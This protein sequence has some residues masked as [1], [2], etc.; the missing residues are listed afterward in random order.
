MKAYTLT[1]HGKPSVLKIAEVPEPEPNAGE[2][3]IKIKRIGIN[4]AEI[5]SRKGMYGWA[6][7]LPY[8]LG[9]EA[10]G[11]VEALGENV[12]HRQ[13]GE[14]VIVV[15]PFGSYAE[16]IIVKERQAL[17]VIEPFSPEENAAYA[18]NYMTAWVSLFGM[19]RLRSTDS[20]LIH[21]AAGGVGTAA[22]Q[23]A[24]HFGCTV[25]GTAGSDEKIKL[26]SDLNID[27][28]INYRTQDFENEIK[29]MT[30]GKG[31]DVI[32]EVVGGDVYKKS[33]RLLNPLGR[34]VIAGFA[35]MN[36]QKWNPLSWL[37][38]WRD[39]PKATIMKM[40]EK[41]YGVMATHLG[42]LLPD[43][44]QLQQ[45]WN[46]LCAFMEKNNIKPVVGHI[47]NFE[48]LAKAH[49][50]MESRKSHGKIVINVSS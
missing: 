5:L 45:T 19:A 39:M 25:F 26:L 31:V 28:A 3:R 18:V 11:A 2:I 12:S 49:E 16:K 46:E 15:T 8:I 4:Y 38:T 9:M 24:K 20:V 29:K 40:A 6:P 32:L 47:F 37:R 17:P 33:L 7:K 48:E 21:A 1:K 42:Y 27:G 22:V 50:L 36:L 35:S 34:I 14:P 30:N 13:I 44:K 23:L 10:F 43:E 41:S